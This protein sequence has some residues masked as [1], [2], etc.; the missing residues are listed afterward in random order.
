MKKILFI[1]LTLSLV[2]FISLSCN[3]HNTPDTNDDASSHQPADPASWSPIGHKYV[4]F[5]DEDILT[6]FCFSWRS[7]EFVTDSFLGLE[8]LLGDK[9]YVA[10]ACKYPDVFIFTHSVPNLNNLKGD[11][12]FLDTLT[13]IRT[14]DP[15]RYDKQII[16]KLTK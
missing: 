15:D 14:I 9:E 6:K 16:Y 8:R 12:I 1:L 11:F 7:L 5:D 4:S 13:L 2:A 10:M 3:D